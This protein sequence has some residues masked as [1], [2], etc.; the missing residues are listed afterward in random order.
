MILA[1]EVSER[2]INKPIPFTT[3]SKRIRYLGINLPKEAKDLYI[4]NYDT[5][6]RNGHKHM[7][8]DIFLDWNINI[9]KI[10]ILPKAKFRF[11]GIPFK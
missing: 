10:T 7:E 2:E 11:N 3:A 9:V 4:K 5:D 8:R 6:E 1:C